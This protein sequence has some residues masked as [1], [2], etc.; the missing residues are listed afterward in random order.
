MLWWG[1]RQEDRGGDGS[2]WGVHLWGPD[3]GTSEGFPGGSAGK[4][5][6]CKAGDLGLIPGLGRSPGEG[7]G[8]PLQYSGLENSMD[9]RV[10]GVAKSR[11]GQSGFHFT[12]LSEPKREQSGSGLWGRGLESGVRVWVGAEAGQVVWGQEQEGCCAPSKMRNLYP[13]LGWDPEGL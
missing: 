4:E 10:H 8:Y 11:T 5:S 7:N 13:K 12:S 9:C 6:T 2:L 3:W 1:R